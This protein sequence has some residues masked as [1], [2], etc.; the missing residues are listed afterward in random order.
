MCVC[1]CVCVQK[2]V[3]AQES[4]HDV[5]AAEPPRSPARPAPAS[6]SPRCDASRIPNARSHPPVRSHSRTPGRAHTPAATHPTLHF[7]FS[8]S[9]GAH[10]G[11]PLPQ[12]PL[13]E[14]LPGPTA[15]HVP[16]CSQRT[17]G[18][19][20]RS[21][22]VPCPVVAALT[23][24]AP[25]PA[26]PLLRLPPHSR[27]QPCALDSFGRCSCL[28]PVPDQSPASPAAFPSALPPPFSAPTS[29]LPCTASHI[30]RITPSAARRSLSPGYGRTVG[31]EGPRCPSALGL[32]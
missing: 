32:S 27:P 16:R 30:F 10:Q 24:P 5:C 20:S 18:G 29:P 1:V 22:A 17:P 13:R 26:T 21:S 14:T 31:G 11:S 28:P 15:P 12:R 3:C 9:W 8:P 7:G 23:T 19:R 2:S 4:A 6:C 25:G